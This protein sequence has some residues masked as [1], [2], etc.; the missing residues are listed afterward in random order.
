VSLGT[1]LSLSNGQAHVGFTGATGGLAQAHEIVSWTF[2]EDST[3]PTGNNSPSAPTITEPTSSGQT[4][5][6]F[7][8]HMEI[9]GFTDADA[10]DL[11]FCTD[12][13]I[14]TVSPAERVWFASCVT[15]PESVHAHLADGVFMGSLAGQT[16]LAGQESYEIR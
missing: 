15:G 11:Q 4:L 2:T 9:R 13:E 7:D 6:P 12:W 1:L 5:N 14:W 10:G 3:P 16:N 8:V